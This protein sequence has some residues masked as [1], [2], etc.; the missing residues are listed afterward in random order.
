[1]RMIK[2]GGFP[3]RR[4]VAM[5]AALIVYKNQNLIIFLTL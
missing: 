3:K 2:C 1:M 4:T 5:S